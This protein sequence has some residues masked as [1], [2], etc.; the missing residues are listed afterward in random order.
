MGQ[1]RQLLLFVFR[2]LFVYL[3]SMTKDR[4]QILQGIYFLLYFSHKSVND[5]PQLLYTTNEL[6][7]LC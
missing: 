3:I 6:K 2:I 1:I 5:Q 4:W 7:L